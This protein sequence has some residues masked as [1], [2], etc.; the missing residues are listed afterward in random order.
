[1]KYQFYNTIPFK[2]GRMPKNWSGARY[3]FEDIWSKQGKR[4]KIYVEAFEGAESPIYFSLERVKSV[5]SCVYPRDD[6]DLSEVFAEVEYQCNVL[7]RF[8]DILYE[9]LDD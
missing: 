6:F 1:M 4:V 5:K 9:V 8:A 2:K 3:F 7:G